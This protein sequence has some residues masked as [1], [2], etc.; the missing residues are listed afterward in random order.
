[1]NIPVGK[2]DLYPWMALKHVPGIGNRI[3]RRL[4]L[5]FGE[6]ARVLGAP[7]DRL[8]PVEGM[9]EKLAGAVSACRIT[10]RI[11]K[12]VASFQEK[13]FRLITQNDPEYPPLL[14]EIHD[15]PPY[16]YANGQ[17]MEQLPA[18]AVV[19][20]RNPTRY[21]ISMA[22][23][24]SADLASVGFVII[25]G[26]ARGID[27]AAHQ[28]ALSAG[29]KTIAVL[30]SGLSVIYPPEN[31]SLYSEIAKTGTVIS[32]LP[33]SEPPNAFNFPARNRIIAGMTLGTV[34]VEAAQK[35]GSLITARLAA[36]QGREVFAVPGNI[37]SY[38]STGAHSLLKHGAKLVE[39]VDD[40]I[41]EL[42]H[43]IHPE[44][45]VQ[46]RRT[47]VDKKGINCTDL[48]SE[49]TEIYYSLDPYPVHI[50]DLAHRLSKDTASLSAVL[51]KLELKG[52]ICQMPG[53]YFCISGE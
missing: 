4:I 17:V 16:L 30:G 36:E 32:E 10:D 50:D 51:L 31:K 5:E 7:R 47:P 21:G 27:T 48:T 29:G 33:A 18:L 53:K 15:P 12:E 46:T 1:M 39:K 43:F 34:V 19:G 9:S 24:L 35:S 38:K 20:S 42:N 37:N 25:S 40:I 3:F 8:L 41:D 14:L 49:E 45:S 13:G 23:R 6:P 26:M 52:M 28:G 11:R 22:R 2:D 44:P